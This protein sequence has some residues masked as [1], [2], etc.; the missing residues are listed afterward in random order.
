MPPRGVSRGEGAAGNL[1]R[2]CVISAGSCTL[3]ACVGQGDVGD[4]FGCDRVLCFELR[5]S[6]DIE[7][8]VYGR[9]NF[10]RVFS[11]EIESW[12]WS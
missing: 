9:C 5:E 11:N 3:H 4:F 10:S 8:F 6:D 7:I 2:A 1:A 12:I